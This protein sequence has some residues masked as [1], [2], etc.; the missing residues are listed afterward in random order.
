MKIIIEPDY[1]ALSKRAAKIVAERVRK[2]P[3]IVLMWKK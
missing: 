2:K 1:E 3:D